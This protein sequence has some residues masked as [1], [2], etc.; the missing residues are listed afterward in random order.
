M[1]AKNNDYYYSLTYGTYSNTNVDKNAIPL[2]WQ[3]DSIIR[4]NA[5]GAFIH[6]Y[7]LRVIE[8][9]DKNVNDKETDIVCITAM[10]QSIYG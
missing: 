5:Y 2:Y 7:I 8:D 1:L 3:T 9:D 10:S 4:A 6:Y